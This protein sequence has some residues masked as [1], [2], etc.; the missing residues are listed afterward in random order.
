MKDERNNGGS[1]APDG[2]GPESVTEEELSK[3][4]D[5]F[6]GVQR[7]VVSEWN[8]ADLHGLTHTQAGILVKLERFG[9]Q[10]AS[11]L[12]EMLSVTSGAITGI[13]DKLL[14]L[15]FIVRDRNEDDRRVV[16][17]GITGSGR[18]LVETIMAKRRE[19]LNRMFT[20]L[21]R[22]EIVQ[23]TAIYEHILRNMEQNE[24][25]RMPE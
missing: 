14:E 13:A 6:R 22:E 9:P 4:E 10:K 2:T 18:A 21:S 19:I 25:R 5:A 16:Q 23:L 24:Q 17:L 8:K 3:L 11:A 15:G 7:K 1:G 12:A 20:G